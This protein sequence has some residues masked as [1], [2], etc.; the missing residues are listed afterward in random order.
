[1]IYIAD[2]VKDTTTTTGTGA[3]TL[4]GTAAPGGYQTF[5]T[6]F[7][8]ASVPVSYVIVDSTNSTF[9]VGD[10]TFDGTTGLTRD[11]VRSSSNAGALVSF[12]S[13]TKDVFCSIS[14]AM[15]SSSNSGLALA[16]K[17]GYQMF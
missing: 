12:A 4:S 15:I 11:Y 14:A 10:G 13:G 5:A 7:G 6:A 9:E 17:A 2:R 8:A 3:I 1:M 16:T